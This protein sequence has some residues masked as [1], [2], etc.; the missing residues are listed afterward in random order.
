[1][2]AKGFKWII[3][4][5]PQKDS[6]NKACYPHSA[7]EYTEAGR[8]WSWR[9]KPGLPPQKPDLSATALPS[10]LAT[11]RMLMPL[12]QLHFPKQVISPRIDPDYYTW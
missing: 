10:H 6:A 4:F 9:S 1:M 7:D 5:N 2:C 11:M 8:S 3:S 12:I